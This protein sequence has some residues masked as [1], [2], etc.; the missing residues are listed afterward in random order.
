MKPKIDD[1]SSYANEMV[2][3][4]LGMFTGLEEENGVI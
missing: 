1:I 2:I 3:N 4:Y